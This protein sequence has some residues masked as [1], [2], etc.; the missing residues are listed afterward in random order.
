MLGT[1]EPAFGLLGRE[2]AALGASVVAN[3]GDGRAPFAAAILPVGPVRFYIGEQAV[4][5]KLDLAGAIALADAAS[6]PHARLELGISMAAGTPIFTN[7]SLDPPHYG[8]QGAGVVGFARNGESRRLRGHE[9]VHVAQYD[10]TFIAWGEPIERAVVPTLPAGSLVHPYV[11]LGA[12]LA[13]FWLGDWILPYNQRP[14][15]REA[16]LLANLPRP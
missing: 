5:V 10:F 9:L 8:V 15:E 14:W 3:A 7:V 6:Q 4:R 11:D 13:F 16:Y 1:G 12:N 2:V